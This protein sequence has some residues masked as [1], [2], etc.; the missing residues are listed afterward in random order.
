M[1]KRVC[2]TAVAGVNRYDGARARYMNRKLNTW[3]FS[4]AAGGT[5]WSD[6]DGDE[7]YGDF[8]V[9]GSTVTNTDS[10]Q[11][12]LW[13]K[14]AGIADYLHSDMLGTLRQ[15][16]GTTGAAAGSDGFTAF[17]GRQAGSSDRFGYVGGWGCH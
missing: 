6:Y 9:S 7:I 8:T 12:G 11:P 1:T 5:V 10:Y 2:A 3:D 4:P 15:T 13:R 16:T 14:V 17:G